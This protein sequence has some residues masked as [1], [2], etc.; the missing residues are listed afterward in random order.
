[1]KMASMAWIRARSALYTLLESSL[2]F[3]Q[4]LGMCLEAPTA[5]GQV[6]MNFKNEISGKVLKFNKYLF[7]IGKYL[8]QLDVFCNKILNQAD[9]G[10]E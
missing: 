4:P 10:D 8:Q 2:W 6:K 5:K 3:L 9:D 7:L 1:M